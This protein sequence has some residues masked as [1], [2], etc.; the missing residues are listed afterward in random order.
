MTFACSKQQHTKHH[1]SSRL[2]RNRSTSL[3]Q[4]QS[5]AEKVNVHSRKGFSR[6]KIRVHPPPIS[7]NQKQ[8]FCWRYRQRIRPRRV[9][10]LREKNV[11][12]TTRHFSQRC[13]GAPDDNTKIFVWAEQTGPFIA[14][15]A[16]HFCIRIKALGRGFAA[17]SP[18]YFEKVEICAFPLR[19]GG[20]RERHLENR[21]STKKVKFPQTWTTTTKVM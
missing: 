7:Q 15:E 14:R 8:S 19:C 17:R 1:H 12:V 10:F 3:Q 9:R 20:R 5:L 21:A 16:I 2:D 18:L 11:S 4:H 13:V 6:E